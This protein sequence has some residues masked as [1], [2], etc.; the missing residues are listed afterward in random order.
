MEKK[1]I[2]YLAILATLGLLVI[3]SQSLFAAIPVVKT[4]PWVAS[5]SLIAHDTWSG[6]TITLKGT[7]DSSCASGCTYVWDFG[8]GTTTAPGGTAVSDIYNIEAQ[9]AYSGIAVGDTITARLTVKRTATGET[10]SKEYYIAM[11]A[12]SIDVEVN[13]AIDEGLWYLHKTIYRYTSGSEPC[14][15]WNS[16]Y[17]GSGYYPNTA[18]NANAFFVNGHLQNGSAT[19]PYTETVQRS[20]CYLPQTLAR[21]NISSITFPA[22]VGGPKNPDGNGNGFALYVTQGSYGYTLGP[23]ID[24]F[25]A[26][27]EPNRVTTTGGADVIGRTYKDL[28]QDMVDW[29]VASMTNSGTYW[30]GWDYNGFSSRNDFSVAQWGAI[31]LIAAEHN[32]GISIPQWV[33]DANAHG[34]RTMQA[35]AGGFGYDSPGYY[36]WGQW[37]VTPSGMVQA[38]LDGIGR[39]DST[40][41][42]GETIIRNNFCNSGGASNAVRDYYYGLFSMTK[43]MLLHNVN[44]VSA[45]ITLMKSSTAGVN[46]I[47]WYAA[48]ASKG[49]PCDGVART[50]VGDQNAAGYW[51]GHNYTGEQYTFETAWAIIMLNRTVFASGLP[52][53]VA[54]AVPNPAV[55]GQ[56]INLSGAASFHQD[57]SKSIVGWD[58][59]LDNSGTFETPG[60]TASVSFGSLGSYPV[61]LK[62][63]DNSGKTA[64]TTVTVLVTVPPVAP[65]ANAGGPYN[66][67]PGKNWFLDG[68]GSIN[69]DEGQS[70]PTKPA[71]TIIEYSWDLPPGGSFGDAYGATPDV[72]AYFTGLGAGS[73]VVQLRVTD[74]TAVSFPS[75]GMGNLSDTDSAQVFVRIATD[76]ACACVSNLAARPKPGKADLTWTWRANAHHYNVYRGTVNGGPYLKIGVVSSAGL[77]NTGVYADSGLTNGGTYYYIVREAAAN[78]DELCQSNQAMAKPV[79]R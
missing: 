78:N 26:S 56:V 25:V 59:D 72:T 40:W 12:K 60:V 42:K 39:L 64:T 61:S 36:P 75:S 49:D 11:R 13:V 35:A 44:G 19:N 58:W 50:L 52:V 73:Y 7:V 31:G 8:D 21:R 62:V 3:M 45:P 57:A 77:P 29:Y 14:G 76:P 69:P 71:N 27:G 32:F 17:A 43:A 5:N 9:R 79:A 66:F 48:E 18:V 74:N 1:A 28:V 24:A 53:A 30:G 47:D 65:T 67:C 10:G 37:A 23:V 54:T 16:G 41:D 38:A 46:P 20:M 15:Y 70:E 68:R 34:V 33:K 2:R 4:V 55:A 63:T 51:Y 22:P 6:K